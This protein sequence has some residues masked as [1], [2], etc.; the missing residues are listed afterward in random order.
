MIIFTEKYPL[1]II[2]AAVEEDDGESVSLDLNDLNF[3]SSKVVMMT[4]FQVSSI[5][6]L[7]VKK[8]LLPLGK[9]L[10]TKC[11]SFGKYEIIVK[12]S[13][14]LI[15]KSY[16]IVTQGSNFLNLKRDDV[17]LSVIAPSPTSSCSSDVGEILS[18][19]DTV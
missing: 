2:D 8:H 3:N 1:L 4:Y 18:D 19:V 15:E 17:M 13:K 12:L 7:G 9:E 16:V 6:E 14:M 10:C 5:R 11:R